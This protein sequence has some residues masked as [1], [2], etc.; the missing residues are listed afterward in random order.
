MGQEFKRFDGLKGSRMQVDQW[1]QW[2]K[3]LKGPMVQV[4]L[5][6]GLNS[7]MI[8]SA[9]FKGIN[10]SRCQMVQTVKLVLSVNSVNNL[11]VN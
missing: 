3:G 11:L 5:L 4:E 1:F 6:D 2:C 7:S 10:V 9:K 8:R